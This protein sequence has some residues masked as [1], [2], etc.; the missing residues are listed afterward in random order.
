MVVFPRGD[1]EMVWMCLPRLDGDKDCGR[2]RMM[3]GANKVFL[4]TRV[5][6]RK[7]LYD[8]AVVDDGVMG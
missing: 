7:K 1:Y 5:L 4:I 6:D 3:M 8:M 2:Q